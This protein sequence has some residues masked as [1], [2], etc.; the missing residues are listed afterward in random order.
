MYRRTWGLK[1]VCVC[2]SDQL[3]LIGVDHLA[4]R[5]L[6]EVGQAISTRLGSRGTGGWMWRSGGVEEWRS[7]KVIELGGSWRIMNVVI[8]VSWVAVK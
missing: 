1:L 6:E 2:S 7:R 4:T 3:T 8:K 5:S